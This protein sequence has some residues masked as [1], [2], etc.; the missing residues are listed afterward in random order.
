MKKDRLSLLR[1]ESLLLD[2]SVFRTED[3][4]L[5]LPVAIHMNLLLLERAI[6]SLIN[7]L[8]SADSSISNQIRFLLSR[9]SCS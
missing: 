7:R 3:A 2:E 9:T 4:T 6:L 1:I 8:V 5:P